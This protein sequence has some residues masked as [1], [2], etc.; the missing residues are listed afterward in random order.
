MQVA[1]FPSPDDPGLLLN[2]EEFGERL[3]RELQIGG[4]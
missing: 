3:E 2:P 1:V 4:E